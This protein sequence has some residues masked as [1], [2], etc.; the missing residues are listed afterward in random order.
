ML[1]QTS[2][3]PILA[4]GF[5]ARKSWAL[6]SW[7]RMIVPLPFS[8]ITVAVGPPQTVPRGLSSEELEAERSHLQALLNALARR[9]EEP[10]RSCVSERKP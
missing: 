5:A 3:A 9:A 1:A 8:R 4:F 7:D 2:R 10:P 6:K